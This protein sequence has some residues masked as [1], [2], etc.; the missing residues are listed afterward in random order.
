VNISNILASRYVHGIKPEV[1][2]QGKILKYFQ[3]LL[4]EWMACQKSWMYL[5]PIFHAQDAIKDLQRES[6]IFT[7]EVDVPF[8]KL[9]KT[10]TE[11]FN[12]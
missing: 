2:A 8:K 6:K 9:L 7:K 5:E 11:N 4:D 10:A 3:E 12:N 1:E